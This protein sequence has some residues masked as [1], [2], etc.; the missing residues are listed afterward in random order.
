MVVAEPQ[1]CP[2]LCIRGT[3]ADLSEV[4]DLIASACLPSTERMELS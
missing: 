3:A 1:C 2:V 4:K